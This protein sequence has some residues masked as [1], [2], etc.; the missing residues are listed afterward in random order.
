MHKIYQGHVKKKYIQNSNRAKFSIDNSRS[1]KASCE[2]RP[3]QEVVSSFQYQ[4]NG[5]CHPNSRL[6]SVFPRERIGYTHLH[7][8]KDEEEGRKR[9][10]LAE[11][12][13]GN[14]SSVPVEV[15]ATPKLVVSGSSILF[16]FSFSDPR[17]SS[18]RRQELFRNLYLYV[19]LWGTNSMK[20]EIDKMR[21]DW[22]RR[23]DFVE[24]ELGTKHRDEI[25]DTA[26]A[27]IDSLLVA[28]SS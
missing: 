20:S 3:Q 6:K 24:F 4:T 7:I 8:R 27:N 10:E 26:S 2:V 17:N 28:N 16:S 14:Y 22:F 11:N 1:S 13:H 25:P 18:R 12:I 19:F 9:K 15:Q 21:T 23:K 5:I